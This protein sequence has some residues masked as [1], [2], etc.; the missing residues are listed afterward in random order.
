M[1]VEYFSGKVLNFD[2]FC[3]DNKLFVPFEW[4]RWSFVRLFYYIS[5]EN[6]VWGIL[7]KH[8][9]KPLCKTLQHWQ[10]YSW[11]A[12]LLTTSSSLIM[13]QT[14]PNRTL[15]KSPTRKEH[16]ECKI[17]KTTMMWIIIKVKVISRSH[18]RLVQQLWQTLFKSGIPLFKISNFEFFVL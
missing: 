14:I 15:K 5:E 17:S 1:G 9:T 8:E 2:F 13:T 3:R 16:F 18:K 10:Q 12:A 11:Q 4:S 6:I 7:Q